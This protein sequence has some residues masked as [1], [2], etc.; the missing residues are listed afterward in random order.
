M[1]VQQK[2]RHGNRGREHMAD[3]QWMNGQK[4][5][6]RF[7]TREDTPFI[8]R[9]RNNPRVQDNFIYKETFTGQTH[10]AWIRDHVEKGDAVQFIICENKENHRPVGSVYFR[11]IDRD[12]HTAEYGIFIGE[13]DAIGRG[14]AN[15]A[16]FLATEYAFTELKIE[17]IILRVFTDNEPAKRSYEHAGF[18]FVRDLP[19]V[20]C[21]DGTKRDM[22]MMQLRKDNR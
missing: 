15:E 13:D 1:F 4:I 12:A 10:N 22:M 5:S 19:Q 21:S 7:M 16:A 11:D 20:M 17:Q 3:V 14:Y 9:W 6:L 2:T 18:V 8:I